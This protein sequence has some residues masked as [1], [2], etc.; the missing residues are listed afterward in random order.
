VPFPESLS[1]H[2]E[3]RRLL[4]LT[5]IRARS[6]WSEGLKSIL[7]DVELGGKLGKGYSIAMLKVK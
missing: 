6:T 3:M 4:Q 7:D 2:S 1:W 5:Q